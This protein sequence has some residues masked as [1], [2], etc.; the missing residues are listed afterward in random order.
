MEEEPPRAPSWAAIKSRFAAVRWRSNPVA[1][2]N[3]FM[4]AWTARALQDRPP[5]AGG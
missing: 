1:A 3:E 4:W 5:P 2:H